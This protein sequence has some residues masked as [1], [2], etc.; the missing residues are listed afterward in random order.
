MKAY[1]HQNNIPNMKKSLQFLTKTAWQHYKKTAYRTFMLLSI[2]F[3]IK[4]AEAQVNV[5][6]QAQ[7]PLCGGFSTGVIT[8]IATGGI[9][10]YTYQWSNGATSNPITNLPTGTYSVTV[11]SSTGVTGT[12]STTLTAPPPLGAVITVTNC[13]IPGSMSVMAT[14][15][16]LPYMYMWSTGATSTSISNLSPGEYCVTVMDNNNCGYAACQTI[17]P[18]LNVIVNT[19]PVIC[20][21]MVGGTATAS[22]T[23]G[24]PPFTYLWNTGGTT[25]TLMNLA[26]GPYFVTVTGDNGCSATGNGTVGMTAGNFT[27]NLNVTQ[28]TCAGSSTGSIVTTVN[29]GAPPLTYAWSSGQNTQNIS[30]LTAGQYTVTVTDAL[31]CSA[32]KSATLNYQSNLTV[33]LNSTNPACG[34]ANTGSVSAVVNN[35]ATPYS[36]AW[37]NGASTQTIS[38]LGVGTYTVTVT[39]NLNCTK[40]ATVTLTAPAS[41]S[42]SVSVTNASHCGLAD[43]SVLAVIGSGGTPPFTYAWNNGSTSFGQSGLLAGT[44]TVTVTSAQGCTASAS[45]TVSQPQTLNVSITG[46]SLVCGSNNDGFLTANPTYG[47]PP[48]N[49][50][51][52]N[53]GATQTITNLA[54]GTYT[55]TV[56]SSQGCT[57]TAQKVINGIP[58]IVVNFNVENVKCFGTNSGKI[59]VTASGGTPPLSYLWSNGATSQSLFNINAGSYT[60]TVTDNVGCSKVQTITVTQPQPLNITFNTS[61]GSCGTTGFINSVVTGGSLP[62]TYSWSSGQTTQN[63]SNLPPGNYSVTVTDANNCSASS[64]TSITAYPT[65]TLDVTS[66]NTTCNGLTDGTATAT[67]SGGTPP[68]QYQ[69]NSN[70]TTPT[71]T[72]LSPGN[73]AVTVTDANGCTKSGSATVLLGTGLNVSIDANIYVCPGEFGSATANAAGGNSPYTWLWSNTET[74]QSITGLAPATY[75]VTATDV[76][77][78][79][80]T[81]SVTLLPG[82]GHAV[83]QTIQHVSCNGAS[84]GSIALNV[85]GGTT[86]FTYLWDNGETTATGTGLAAGTYNVTV[87]DATDCEVVKTYTV[88]EPAVLAVVFDLFN[89]NCLS[90]GAVSALPS[91]GTMPYQY[92]WSTGENTQSIFN[93]TTGTYFLTLTD[94]HGCSLVDSFDITAIPVP[95]CE[96]NLDQNITSINGNDGQLTAVVTGGTAPFTYSWNNGQSTP[97]ISNLSANF[98]EVTISD[99]NACQTIC[100]LELYNP[101]KVGDFVWIDAD[102]DGIQDASEN[103]LGGVT[104]NIKGTDLYGNMVDQNTTTAGNGMYMFLMVP[105]SYKITFTQPAGYAPSPS[106]QGTNDDIDSDANVFTGMTSMFTLDPGETNLTID[107]GYYVAP[108]CINVTAPGSICC[109]QTLCGPGVDPAPLTQVTAPSGGSGNLEFLW[110]FTTVPGPFDPNG[111]TVIN[112]S[113]SPDYDPGPIYETTYFIR[114]VRRENCIEF[115]ES[116]II[117]ITVDTVAVAQINGP[118]GGCVNTPIDFT[119]YNNGP[120]ATYAWNFGDGTPATATTQ[121]VPGVTWSGFGLKTVTLSVTRNGCTSTAVHQI[122]ITNLPTFCGN[123]LVINANAVN[124]TAVSVDWFYGKADSIQR[125]YTV[126]WAWGNNDFKPIPVTLDSVQVDSFLHFTA[127]HEQA[128]RGSNFYRVTL[129]D[130]DGTVIDLKTG[131]K[132]NVTV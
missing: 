96:I 60:L 76:A 131:I 50:A 29:G 23:G 24:D 64:N 26:P 132:V 85:T 61:G 2:F 41:F 102:E 98:Y 35:G 40:T 53:G 10:P 34:G 73:Y 12:A 79:F 110:M 6:L 22:T 5:I 46:S 124:R 62:Y 86:P 57:G 116:N 108:P 11:T 56:T 58:A 113:N 100:N 94:A 77:G 55:V 93:L 36:Y 83:S 82:G 104:V 130:S 69:W 125:T 118:Q 127:I 121:F 3:F 84:D 31:G 111:W 7:P 81:A 71:I 47:N 89:G 1:N 107:A 103:G 9:A 54:P 70:P 32:T 30:N 13:N 99:A 14:G 123:A 65:M 72:N 80:G 52:S 4:T 114:C 20:G 19:T 112:N 21:N 126:E 106:N 120:G 33:S 44:Y 90:Q 122:Y 92:A 95:D 129:N 8:A 117:T 49:Y 67:P 38:N 109:D 119:A 88:T 45:G 16:I 48:Y 28:P 15:G 17:G 59:I 101:A 74:T 63:I 105:G 128:V 75:N 25:P 115:L 37:S 27:V 18:V 91:G 78:C 87:S 42:V 51:W 39:D 43:G 68:Y 66:T 97:T